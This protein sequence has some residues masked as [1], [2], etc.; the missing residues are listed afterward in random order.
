MKK[1]PTLPQKPGFLISSK[2]TS[3]TGGFG[4]GVGFGSVRPP[5]SIT[6]GRLP[7]PCGFT[8][9]TEPPP[10]VIAG[11]LPPPCGVTAGTLAPDGAFGFGVNPP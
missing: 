11:R 3:S 6:A 9:G 7:P 5:S 4:T 8:G 1:S 10:P 2:G